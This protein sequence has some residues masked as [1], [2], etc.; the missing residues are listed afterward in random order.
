M[1]VT[2]RGKTLTPPHPTAMTALTPGKEKPPA[3][4]KI[5]SFIHVILLNFKGK[6]TVLF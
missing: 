5:G 3:V 2:G 6:N 4:T 1:W